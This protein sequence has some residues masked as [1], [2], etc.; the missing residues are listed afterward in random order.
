MTNDDLIIEETVSALWE[1]SMGVN[2]L[3]QKVQERLKC[4]SIE[5]TK[6][7]VKAAKLIIPYTFDKREGCLLS[8][9]RMQ[10]V[11]EKIN[12]RQKYKRLR[13]YDDANY[14]HRGL[15]KMGVIFNDADKTWSYEAPSEDQTNVNGNK[16]AVKSSEAC[17]MCGLLFKSRNLVFKHL[18]DPGSRCGNSIFVAGDSLPTAPSIQKKVEKKNK[19]STALIRPRARTGRTAQHANKSSCLWMGDLPLPWTRVGGKYK[20]FRALL[21]QY[22]PSDIPQPW[23]KIVV[24]KAYRKRSSCLEAAESNGQREKDEY[25]GYAIVV[26]RCDE[27][28]DRIQ[29]TINGLEILP[30]EVF[31]FDELREDQLSQLP[32]FV[33]KIRA[34]ENSDS[35][36]TPEIKASGKDPPLSEQLRPLMIDELTTRIHDL[37]TNIEEDNMKLKLNSYDTCKESNRE[38][39]NQVQLHEAK[40]DEVVGLY[41]LIG[42]RKEIKRQGRPVPE[43]LTKP[44]LEI[45][46]SLRWQVPNERRHLSAERYLVLPTNVSYDK[47]YGNLR[48]ACKKLMEWADESYFYSGIAV[49]STEFK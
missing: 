34:V 36:M 37:K 29:Q 17:E 24:R 47:F 41:Q 13:K 9:E 7:K 4:Q 10:F 19:V 25:L 14:I 12:E 32:S 31:R 35:T 26:F 8:E 45:L 39:L 42:P 43:Y 33:L 2:A 40:L 16:I 38:S 5:V 1:P 22:L 18:R 28:A 30:N 44:L 48:Q 3:F 11:T 21:R 27:E 46:Q 20:R 6:Q 23:V 49:V 15:E